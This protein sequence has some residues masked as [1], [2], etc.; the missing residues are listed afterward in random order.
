MTAQEQKLDRHFQVLRR[1]HVTEKSSDDMAKRNAYT[2]R[3]PVN[4]NKVE[5]RQAVEKLFSVK[6]VS[7]NTLRVA[8]RKRRRGWLGGQSPDW[9]KAM[10]VLTEGQTLDVL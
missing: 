3:V 9:K 8:G 1:T 4:A 7:V 6:V 10:V 5:I 2:F